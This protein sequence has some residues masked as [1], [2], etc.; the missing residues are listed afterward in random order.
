MA[1]PVRRNPTDLIA[2][3]EAEPHRF[4]FFQAVRLL[5]LAAPGAG[6]PLFLPAGVRFRTPAS[7]A[8]PASDLAGPARRRGALL[9]LE[10]GFLGL[11]GPAGILPHAYTELVL[12]RRHRHR[13]GAL[14]AFLDLFSHRACGLFYAAWRKYRFPI[15]C[16]QGRGD[17]FSGRLLDLLPVRPFPAARAL[18]PAIL[19][20]FAGL[21]GRRPLP[22]CALTAFI[23]TYFQV[24]VGLDGFRGQ[25][26]P[27]PPPDRT[28]LGLAGAALGA[29][30]FLGGRLWDPQTRIRIRLGPLEGYRFRDFL[31]GRAGARA[32]AEFL[33]MHLGPWLACDLELIPAPGALP[34]PALGHGPRLG[35]DSRLP[36]ASPPP[37]AAFRLL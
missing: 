7:L 14:H 20:H 23:A 6:D 28:R 19:A 25:W 17:R 30:A 21:L 37:P 13:D 5:A 18:A 31:P 29:G 36:A 16:E 4:P 8:F 12:E 10:V 26:T 33:A 32:L 27:V 3:L 24:Q 22:A 11:T 1:P 15:A 9:E 35:L 2:A 34:P